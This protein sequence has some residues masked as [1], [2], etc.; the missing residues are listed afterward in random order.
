MH[1]T[2]VTQCREPSDIEDPIQWSGSGCDFAVHRFFQEHLH[3]IDGLHVWS[4]E[5][6]FNRTRKHRGRDQVGPVGHRRRVPRAGRSFHASRGHGLER[7]GV[8]FNFLIVLAAVLFLPIAR[9]AYI[10]WQHE[11]RRPEV[12]RQ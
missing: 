12:S 10:F 4:D 1:L 11:P 6:S 9:R 8:G 3:Q 2:V 5:G 7:M